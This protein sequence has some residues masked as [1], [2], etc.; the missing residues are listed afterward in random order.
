MLEQKAIIPHLETRPYVGFNPVIPHS[1]AGCL[2]EP[3]VSVPV[4]MLV[5]PAATQAAE[6]PELPQV[7]KIPPMD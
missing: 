5:M 7:L 4:E 3:P 2:I 6:P 1:A